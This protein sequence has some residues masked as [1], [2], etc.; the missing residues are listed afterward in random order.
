MES[1]SSS[2]ETSEKKST[3]FIDHIARNCNTKDLWAAAMILA[4]WRSSVKGLHL[5]PL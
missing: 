1:T 5:N 3:L 4:T 2:Q